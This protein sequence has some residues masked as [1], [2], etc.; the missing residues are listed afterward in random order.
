[1]NIVMLSGNVGRE[2]DIRYSPAGRCVANFSVATHEYLGKDEGGMSKQR[3]TWHDVVAFGALGEV[4]NQKVKAGSGVTLVGS[5]QNRPWED[6]SGNKRISKEIVISEL[7]VHRGA[8]VS[9]GEMPPQQPV[10]GDMP[11]DGE[12]R[13]F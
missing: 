9:E 10:Y 4:V 5:I 2:P 6:K 1:M 3:T 7:T 13:P 8:A 11:H 12:D